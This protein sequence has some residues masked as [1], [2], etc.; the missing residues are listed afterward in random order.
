MHRWNPQTASPDRDPG[1]REGSVAA[2]TSSSD[3]KTPATGRL[4]L[5]VSSLL[6]LLV[7]SRQSGTRDAMKLSLIQTLDQGT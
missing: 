4:Y 3:A 5:P 7:V 1:A 2:E 6:S